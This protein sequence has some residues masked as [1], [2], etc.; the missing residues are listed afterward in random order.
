MTES[1]KPSPPEHE[2]IYTKGK[3]I[4]GRYTVIN[5]LG[6]GG[7]AEVYHCTDTELEREVAVKVIVEEGMSIKEAKAAAKLEH[8]NI[9]Q[10]YEATETKLENNNFLVI[11]F[12]YIN[13]DT[14]EKKLGK[15]KYRRLPLDK[16]TLKTIK[17]IASAVDFAHGKK[18]IHRDIKPSNILL[19]QDGKAYLTDF[20]LAEIKDSLSPNSMMTQ[21]MA[22]RLSGTIPYMAPEQLMELKPADQR[23]DLYSLGVVSYEMLTGRFPYPGRDTKLI[24]QIGTTEP[25]PPN[26]ANPDLPQNLNDVLLKALD[27]DPE[28]RYESCLEFVNALDKAT[29]AYLQNNTQYDKAVSFM[30]NKAWR[31]ALTAFEALKRQAPSNF[32]DLEF[33]LERAQRK[34]RSLIQFEQAQSLFQKQ[35][36]DGALEA[37]NFLEQAD[38]DFAIENLRK[39]IL[40]EKA[41]V[42]QQSRADL[43]QQA[44][45]QYEEGSYEESL[46]SINIIL[47]QDPN[48]DDPQN[49]QTQAQAKADEQQ[50]WHELYTAGVVAMNAES[51]N[52][53]LATFTTLRTEN[54]HYE[55][56]ETRLVMARHLQRLSG[57]YDEAKRQFEEGDFSLAIDKLDELTTIDDTYKTTRVA[58]LREESLNRLYSKSEQLLETNNFEESKAIATALQQRSAD[59]PQLD[60]LQARIEHSIYIRDLQ[61]TLDDQYKEAQLKLENRDYFGALAIWETIAAHQEEIEFRDES[62]VVTRAKDGIYSVA[63]SALVGTHFQKALDTWN[64]LHQLDPDYED[65]EDIAG[66]AQAGLDHRYFLKKMAFFAGITLALL[67][68]IALFFWFNNNNKNKQAAFVAGETATA[69]AV[70]PPTGTP[71]NTPTITPTFT[72]TPTA[73]S[74][75]TNTPTQT[76]TSTPTT[77]ATQTPTPTA[78]PSLTGSV[79]GNVN[80]YA[81]PDGSGEVITFIPTGTQV[82][83]LGRPS[84]GEWILLQT[85]ETKGYGSTNFV[86]LPSGMKFEDLPIVNDTIAPATAIPAATISADWPTPT[87]FDAAGTAVT[88]ESATIFNTPDFAGDAANLP[89]VTAG[90]IVDL[91]G[92]NSTG[93]WLYIRDKNGNEGYVWSEL[94]EYPPEFDPLPI[95][96]TEAS[97]STLDG[98]NSG[99]STQSGATGLT[100]D[101]F[102]NAGSCSGGVWTRPI[103][104]EGRGGDGRYSYYWND[105]LKAGPIS[106]STT[107]DISA[108]NG[109][110]IGKARIESGDGQSVERDFYVPPEDCNG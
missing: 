29:E 109:A 47:T 16:Q 43:Y 107:F 14:L 98:S 32:R 41:D 27:K 33:Q 83:I 37:L 91:I 40:T 90:D 105:E 69:L 81:N 31:Q 30:E 25:M 67:I 5:P 4:A 72:S 35:K 101:V 103:F 78:T 102:F 26:L 42:E 6:F 44:I 70:I 61:E 104:M 18:V 76:A 36:Y 88:L 77:T 23:T 92:Q 2:Y 80:V 9:V 52:D 53:A 12:R 84:Q 68:A 51:W 49:I 99:G 38:P 58:Q 96:N 74:T 59:Y 79:T 97:N 82:T 75:P 57:L 95:V 73:S 34:V 28:Q 110:V 48:F 50:R 100:A 21:D 13:G 60:D 94:F 11:V 46:D 20:G 15:A 106:S 55:D 86:T 71:T 54:P 87:S 8:T 3:I 7:F 89:F 45:R 1:N 24:I 64:E 22:H 39:T 10:V 19:D 65:R 62:A 63:L 17:E 93:K 85:D 108:T 66:R 56:I